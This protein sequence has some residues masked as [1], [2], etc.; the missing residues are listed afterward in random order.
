M[1]KTFDRV[2][3]MQEQTNIFLFSERTISLEQEPPTP[4]PLYALSL[5]YEFCLLCGVVQKKSNL[6]VVE[7]AEAI[8][9]EMK[10]QN[11]GTAEDAAEL[12]HFRCNLAQRGCV[13]D[14]LSVS[15]G[16]LVLHHSQSR[17]RYD[18]DDLYRYPAFR[19]G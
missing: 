10:Q 11:G 13:V 1:S 9:E 7:D 17:R 5:P 18:L 12:D 4:P 2:F 15:C 16:R 14:L 19:N 8:K 6:L 3:E